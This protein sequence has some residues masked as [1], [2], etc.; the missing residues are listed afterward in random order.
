MTV[1]HGAPRVHWAERASSEGGMAAR[2]RRTEAANPYSP[3]S[4]RWQAWRRG[5]DRERRRRGAR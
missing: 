2:E 5:F 3:G 1:R 4:I